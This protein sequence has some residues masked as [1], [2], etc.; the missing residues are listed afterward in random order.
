M[1]TITLSLLMLLGS[2]DFNSKFFETAKDATQDTTLLDYWKQRARAS[3][4][5]TALQRDRP[6]YAAMEALKL[7][8]MSEKAVA[9]K[10]EMMKRVEELRKE[11]DDCRSKK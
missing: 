10:M 6:E 8:K 9:D 1:S 7:K 3:E 2:T 4:K 11:L 5:E